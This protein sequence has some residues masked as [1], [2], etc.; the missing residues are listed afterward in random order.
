MKLFTPRF[1]SLAASALLATTSMAQCLSG[2]AA[3]PG[4]NDPLVG[5]WA[6]HWESEIGLIGVFPSPAAAIGTFDVQRSPSSN[7]L[8]LTG[9]MTINANGRIYRLAPTGTRLRGPLAQYQCIPGTNIIQG[10]TLQLS[11]GSFDTMWQFVFKDN[12]FTEIFM[13]DE[14]FLNPGPNVNLVLKGNA[15]KFDSAIQ[16]ANCNSVPNEMVTNPLTGL[17]TA[18]WSLQSQSVGLPISGPGILGVGGVA[19]IGN[20]VFSTASRPGLTGTV[21]TASSAQP[22]LSFSRLA[23]TAGSYGLNACNNIALIPTSIGNGGNMS[24]MVGPLAVQYEYVF[25]NNGLSGA[26]V[27][28]TLATRNSDAN[29]SF[30]ADALYG[31]LN[32]WN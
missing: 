2:D 5:Q 14:E 16:T 20:L 24:L 15:V 13:V 4:G 1:I 25:I 8:T 12:N 7:F 19:A 17:P 29:F 3:A 27:L 18:W 23:S 26:Y 21:S 31:T 11:D 6:F 9:N 32:R 30:G 10:G 28:S 22:G